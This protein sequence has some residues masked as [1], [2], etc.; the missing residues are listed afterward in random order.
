MQRKTAILLLAAALGGCGGPS[1]QDRHALAHGIAVSG[2]LVER[3]VAAGPFRLAAWVRIDRPGEAAEVYIEGDGRAFTASRRVSPDPTPGDPVA[4]RLAAADRAAPNVIY[5]ARPCQYA[6]D[7][8]CD[9]KYW[10]TA[11]TAP[12]VVAAYQDALNTLKAEYR[13]PALALNG[14][15]GGAAV[16]VLAAEG[17]SD[18]VSIRTVAGNLDYALFTDIHGTPPLHESRD[19]ADAAASLANVPQVHFTGGDDDI[20]P[21]A[22]ARAFAKATGRCAQ[23]EE[24]PGYAHHANWAKTWTDMKKI[25]FTCPQ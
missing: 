21:P 4:L 10:T 19:P 15:S 9:P 1:G 22:I 16:A 18:V 17:R 6:P 23:V 14:Y 25:P 20:V 13:I 24:I 7:A 8:G 12:E 5:L 11:R 3:E 2:G